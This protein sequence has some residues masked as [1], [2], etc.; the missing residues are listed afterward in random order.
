MGFL[1]WENGKARGRWAESGKSQ[2]VL[3]GLYGRDLYGGFAWWEKSLVKQIK[4]CSGGEEPTGWGGWEDFGSTACG[5]DNE[6]RERGDG[7]VEERDEARDGRDGVRE[8]GRVWE[9]VG[10]AF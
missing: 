3:M 4:H 1:E 6:P 10:M 5:A 2:R 8:E 9:R 7:R